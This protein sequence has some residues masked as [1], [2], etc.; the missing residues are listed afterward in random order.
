MPPELV[1]TRKEKKIN[2]LPLVRNK[3]GNITDI[4]NNEIKK[5]YR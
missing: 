2:L 5:R 3:K 1:N 4:I